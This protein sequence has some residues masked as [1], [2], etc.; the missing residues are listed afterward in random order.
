MSSLDPSPIFSI[1]EI[2]ALIFSHLPPVNILIFRRVCRYWRTVIDTTPSLQWKAWMIPS[3]DNNH[4]CPL[5]IAPSSLLG[6]YSNRNCGNSHQSLHARCSI[7]TY[8]DRFEIN[9]AALHL[10][11]LMWQRFMRL[12]VEEHAYAEKGGETA[13]DPTCIAELHSFL[14]Q[15]LDK[16]EVATEKL[17]NMGTD[18]DS[19]LGHLFDT[20]LPSTSLARPCLPLSVVQINCGLGSCNLKPNRSLFLSLGTIGDFK[21]SFSIGLLS[22]M[23][24]EFCPYSAGIVR[25]KRMREGQLGSTPQ[26]TFGKYIMLV[27]FISFRVE[28]LGSSGKLGCAVSEDVKQFVPWMEESENGYEIPPGIDGSSLIGAPCEKGHRDARGSRYWGDYGEEEMWGVEDT[29]Y[30]IGL[31]TVEPYRITSVDIKR[32]SNK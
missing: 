21:P 26:G 7:H 18:T 1:Y 13:N 6:E 19:G 11:E 14:K 16:I 15:K 10:L 24:L 12:P 25:L 27:K 29:V 28:R 5:R 9:P 20:H 17:T 8:T 32:E 2:A 4:R 31:E 22:K 30:S 3:P 23:L